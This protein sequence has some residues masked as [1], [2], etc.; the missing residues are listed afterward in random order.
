VRK[1]V[2]L[3]GLTLL[4]SGCSWFTWLPWVDEDEEDVDELE[5]AALVRFDEE[6]E[7]ERLWKSRVGDGLGS[8]YIRL[9]PIIVADRIFAVDGYGVVASFDRFTG[10]EIWEV[11]IDE[12]DRGFMSVFNFFDRTDES[13]V[14][15]G[16]GAGDGHVLIGLTSGEVVAL[17]VSDGSVNWRVNVGS[18]V[19]SKP[20][21]S[22][23]KVYLQTIDGRLMALDADTGKSIWSFDNQVPILTLR[24]TAS[25]MVAG[26]IVY[27]GFAN[28]ML[29]AFQSDTGEPVW[30]HR[31]QLPEGRSELDRMVDVD[32]QPLLSGPLIY[33]SAYNG[34]L[35]ALRREDGQP[36]WAREYGSY[37][38]LVEGYS[39]VYLV[40]GIDSVFAIDTSSA[41]TV[42]TQE[43]LYRRKLTSPVAFSNYLLV[44]DDEGYL[45]VL[46]QSDGRFV[47]RRKLDG[48]GLRS[49]MVV[50][51][52]RTVYVLTNGG[53]LQAVEI[54][55][56]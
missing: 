5:P 10:K 48:E 38:N 26:D 27:A 39:Q 9:S 24:G 16:V 30:E 47:G 32:G 22:R 25:P 52:G 28:G 8:K 56:R 53:S 33:V 54:S 18:E 13:F 46:A 12:R 21:V 4:V 40:D 11:R 23:G 6:V 50:A 34:E 31:V 29:M 51:E 7:V 17:A 44:G 55:V 19:L 45:H 2:A 15:G 20:A 42:W 37:L 1:A 14:S 49:E 41:E 36:V 43:A 35:K 3:L